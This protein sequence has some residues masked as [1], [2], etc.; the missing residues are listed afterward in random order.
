MTKRLANIS[1]RLATRADLPAINSIY[2]H[3]V[4]H[5]TATYQT[6]PATLDERVAWY[7]GHGAGYPVIVAEEAGEVIAWGSLSRFHPRAAYQ[8]TVEN[9]I[10][11]RHDRLSRG[12][13][14]LILRDLIERAMAMGYHSIVALISADQTA[15][16][17][18][19]ERFGFLRAGQLRQVGRKFG[20]WLDVEYMQLMLGPKR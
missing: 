15:S 19:H 11:V 2:N 17:R 10:Y 8:P 16:V 4:I 3:Y 13:G 5:S 1:L 9:S 18:L 14:T 20:R 7:E 6:E 12:V